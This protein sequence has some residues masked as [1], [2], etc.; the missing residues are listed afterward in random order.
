M[1]RTAD[2][3]GNT[4]CLR[5]TISRCCHASVVKTVSHNDRIMRHTHD[6]TDISTA[7]ACSL[8]ST[9]V[10][11]SRHIALGLT[12]NTTDSSD[13]LC[14]SIF[15]LTYIS[16]HL[17]LVHTGLD[18]S[19]TRVSCNTADIKRQQAGNCTD[20]T[21]VLTAGNS[22][23]MRDFS[24]CTSTNTADNNPHILSRLTESV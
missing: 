1:H 16:K 18:C 3:S 6:T 14:S 17:T 11:A 5:R 23:T 24:R 9:K 7:C 10:L 21:M 22:R 13:T 20:F 8:D 4:S 2:I 12:N 15:G 19:T